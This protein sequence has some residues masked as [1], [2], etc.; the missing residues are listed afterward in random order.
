MRRR[1]T[2]TT[3]GPWSCSG[4][5]RR[6][7]A[8]GAAA[9]G[10]GL[11]VVMLG[12]PKAGGVLGIGR[13]ALAILVWFLVASVFLAWAL[14]RTLTRLHRRVAEQAITDPLTGLWNRRHMAETL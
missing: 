10:D 5:R 7:G 3:G 8:S 12:P 1:W 4:R 2:R 11:T 14:A 13:P 9:Q 6:A